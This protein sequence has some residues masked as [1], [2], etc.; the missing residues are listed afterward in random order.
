MFFA[1]TTLAEWRPMPIDSGGRRLVSLAFVFIIA[2][3]MLFGWEWSVL[4]G[5]AAIGLAMA[6]VRVEPLKVVFNSAAYALAAGL[7]ALPGARVRARQQL[8]LRRPRDRRRLLGRVVRPG[9]RDARLH[10]DRPLHPELAARR[11]PRSPP[12]FGTDLRDHDLRR[13]AG[14]HLLAPVGPARDAPERAALR[15]HAVPALVR[16]PPRRGGGGGNRQPDRPQESP[17]VR[18]RVARRARDRAARRRRRSCSA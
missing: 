15:P 14:R 17:R 5:A 9:Q 6:S 13:D 11:L 4:T 7:A 1:F 3:Q 12:A 8:Q 16:P 10:R 2:C 18:A